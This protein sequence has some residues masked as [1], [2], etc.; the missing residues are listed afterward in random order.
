MVGR[1]RRIGRAWVSCL[2]ALVTA[3]GIGLA[4]PAQAQTNYPVRPVT[5]IVP[6]AAGGGSDGIARLLANYLPEILGQPIVVENRPG[7]G[8]NIGIT[9][10]ARAQPD[11]Y[12]ILVTS[13]AI[14]VNPGMPRGAPFDPFK[15][16]VPLVEVAAGANTL[17]VLPDSPVK[18]IAGLTA[19]SK[20]TPQ[21]LNYA[22]PGVGGVSH[23][24]GE[25]FKRQTG[26]NMTHVPF[27]GAGPATQA[28]MNGSIDLLIANLI[29]TSG[30]VSAGTMRALAQT[31]STRAAAM[32]DVPTL[33]ELGV[34]VV[35]ETIQALFAPAG[36]PPEIQ[37]KLVEAVLS[38]LER[39][40]IRSTIDKM[41]LTMTA[42]GP[43]VLGARLQ[44]EV[45]MWKQI[46]S[47]AKIEPR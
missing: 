43:D 7:A 12:T 22:S 29:S 32:P 38:L 33:Q 5:F 15:D 10:A 41:G 26:T 45:P 2:A 4:S 39:P 3:A 34:D 44:K 1:S 37:Q 8:A 14:I 47:D 9:A 20:E 40:D 42:G 30:P 16:F 13:S 19:R 25:L 18:D 35:S 27:N 28:L 31:G 6:F 21:G 46:I 36:T 24:T 11:G 23:L 17:V